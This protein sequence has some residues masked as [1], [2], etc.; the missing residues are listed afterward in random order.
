MEDSHIL[1]SAQQRLNETENHPPWASSST[2]PPSPS[3][4]AP[5]VAAMSAGGLSEAFAKLAMENGWG[6]AEID[7][8][9]KGLQRVKVS[10]SS[11]GT[12]RGED[13]PPSPIRAD[14]AT[15]QQQQQ[16]QRWK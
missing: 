1:S 11:S 9:I 10:T 6:A 13:G 4:K 3:I 14:P 16:Q 12:S 7:E 2:Q 15:K 8:A 5:P